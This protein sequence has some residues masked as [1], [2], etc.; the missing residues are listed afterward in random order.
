MYE[1]HRP[2]PPLLELRQHME[3]P[4]NH[5]VDGR[6]E[7]AILSEHNWHSFFILNMH[8]Q[9]RIKEMNSL[10]TFKRRS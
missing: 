4:V 1:L 8:G 2:L 9:L 6:C 3:V 5:G 10:S 7:Q